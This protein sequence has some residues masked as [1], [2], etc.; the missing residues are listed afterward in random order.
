VHRS[1]EPYLWDPP[2]WQVGCAPLPP[3]LIDLT[4]EAVARRLRERERAP[5]GGNGDRDDPVATSTPIF[6]AGLPAGSALER[7]RR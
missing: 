7:A 4:N 1:G 6:T 3:S 2:P 5:R